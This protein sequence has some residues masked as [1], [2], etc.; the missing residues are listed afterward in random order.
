MKALLAGLL[1]ATAVE[2]SLADELGLKVAI[3]A[4]EPPT[5]VLVRK[6]E[7]MEEPIVLQLDPTNGTY[8]ALLAR[9]TLSELTAVKKNSIDYRVVARWKDGKEQL[10]LKLEAQL[11]PVVALKIFRNQEQFTD[12]ALTQIEKL[13]SD[14]DSLFEK[15]C[16]ARAFHLHWRFDIKQ[17]EIF[18][19]LRSA[20][21]WFDA[22][23]ALSNWP[24]S[25]LGMD[26]EIKA[27]ME[28]YERHANQDTNFRDRYRKYAAAGYVMGMLDDVA[29]SEYAFV[30][31]IPKLVAAGKHQQAWEMNA[32]ALSV[33]ANE[34]AEM[35]RLVLQRQGVSLD[36][37]RSNETFL[38]KRVGG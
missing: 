19:A 4:K 3:V 36:L 1:A 35:Q 21:V 23:V 26:P 13:G 16:R 8:Y 28:E 2:S 29:T 37:L 14:L 33:L 27:I 25:P 12:A 24:K 9:P 11:P 15:Y 31:Q 10:F 20:K 5:E 34:P 38:S 32:K 17:P 6:A 22:A 30:G 7:G 18:I